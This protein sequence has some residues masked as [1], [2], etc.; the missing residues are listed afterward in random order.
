MLFSENHG[1]KTDQE[2]L[3]PKSTGAQ[4]AQ[5]ASQSQVRPYGRCQ[6]KKIVCMHWSKTVAIDIDFYII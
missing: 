5:T 4:T 6:K 1:T 3:G 2:Q